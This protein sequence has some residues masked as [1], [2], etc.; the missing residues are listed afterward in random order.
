MTQ[1]S[2]TGGRREF[3]EIQTTELCTAD[4]DM[5]RIVAQAAPFP[6]GLLPYVAAVIPGGI[7][8]R[9]AVPMSRPLSSALTALLIVILVSGMSTHPASAGNLRLGLEVVSHLPLGSYRASALCSGED[10]FIIGGRNY[11][12]VKTDIMRYNTSSGETR[13]CSLRLPEP[14]MSA[15]LINTGSDV[16]IV[17]GSDG[18][19]E[20]DTILRFSPSSLELSVVSARLPL[21]RIG[22]FSAYS[23]NYGYIFGGHTS[24]G[25]KTTEILR[26]DP[27]TENITRMNASLPFGRAGSGICEVFGDIF[28][29]G[30]M[31]NDN[32]PTDQILLYRPSNDTLEVL[33]QRLPYP[34][35]HTPAVWWQ[36]SL[37]PGVYLF[38]GCAIQG[39]ASTQLNISIP[40]DK[41][42]RFDPSTYKVEISPIIL[43]SPRERVS[44]V[45]VNSSV[46]VF[47]G[48]LAHSASDEVLRVSIGPVPVNGAP[49]DQH[50]AIYTGIAVFVIFIVAVLMF[51]KMVRQSDRRAR[52]NGKR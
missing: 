30:G 12:E 2:E 8:G 11:T 6:A 17:G 16:F 47:G 44:A 48:Q 5:I 25:I 19:S 21:P 3:I 52:E 27:M 13:L 43:P 29:F 33:D 18:P 10:V 15:S 22:T 51:V 42:I 41:I 36:N 23:G 50:T 39:G 49:G 46:Y 20:L 26:F 45:C 35:Y 9:G 37:A 24:E 4:P 7:H 28:I 1:E 34:I 40:T 38:G 31:S 32:V 14:R